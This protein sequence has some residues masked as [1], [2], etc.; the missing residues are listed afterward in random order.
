MS[1]IEL[2]NLVLYTSSTKIPTA[3]SVPGSNFL[4]PTPLIKKNGLEAPADP[5]TKLGT[6]VCKSIMF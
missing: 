4:E 5:T 3:P 6:D 1:I 2:L